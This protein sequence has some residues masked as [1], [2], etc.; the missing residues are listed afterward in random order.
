M[1]YLATISLHHSPYGNDSYDED[2][3]RLVEADD[4]AQAR[5]KIEAAFRRDDQYGHSIRVGD[6]VLHETIT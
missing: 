5:G 4:E 2:V 3:T 1:L 6:V